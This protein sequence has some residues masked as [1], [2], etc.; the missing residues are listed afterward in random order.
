MALAS[1]LVTSGVAVM[2]RHHELIIGAIPHPVLNVLLQRSVEKTLILPFHTG[3]PVHLIPI[4]CIALCPLMSIRCMVHITRHQFID[5][6]R[7]NKVGELLQPESCG[8]NVGCKWCKIV[9]YGNNFMSG[10]LNRNH[11][12]V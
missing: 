5:M 4:H 2:A 7:K 10:T 11:H 6:D 12:V 3:V 8:A 1:D 9:A